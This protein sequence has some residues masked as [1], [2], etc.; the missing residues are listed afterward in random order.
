MAIVRILDYVR[1]LLMLSVMAF[2]WVV[3]GMVYSERFIPPLEF[4][5][6]KL[7]PWK[8]LADVPADAGLLDR[9]TY[10][11]GILDDSGVVAGI[12]L[13]VMVV[14]FGFL[15][16]YL[17]IL[18]QVKQ[19]R[20]REN[21]LLL[22]KNQ[23][24]A[25]RNE[26]IRYIS[27]TI[28]HEFKNNLGRIKRR[29]DLLPEIEAGARERID[30]NLEK[31]FADIEVF[32]KISDERESGL[33]VFDKVNMKD[34]LTGLAGQYGDMA[35]IAIRGEKP[36]L[37]LFAAPTLLKT[38]FENLIDNSIKYKKPGQPLARISVD[39]SLDADGKRRYV[40]LSFRDE[41]MGMDEAQADQCFYKGARKGPEGGWGQGLYFVKYAV[42]LHAGK[43][44]VGK[45]YTAPGRGTEIIISLPLVEEAIG[46]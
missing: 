46:V 1:R 9:L 29:I 28:S 30:S 36:P 14:S 44:R 26:F 5:H 40:S 13:V 10:M 39:C 24:I 42:G 41:G 15:S 35:E 6:G 21:E 27:A 37:V 32:K 31:L 3:F 11:Q 16:A 2:I 23:E 19:R 7:M 25:R 20:A 33:I 4:L 18:Y 8:R 12:A 38:I 34:M 17:T 43:V 45:D 22:V